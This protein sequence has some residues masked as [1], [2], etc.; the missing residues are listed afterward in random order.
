MLNLLLLFYIRL[1]ALVQTEHLSMHESFRLEIGASCH[2]SFRVGAVSESQL[3][4]RWTHWLQKKA[5]ISFHHYCSGKETEL[6]LHSFDTQII[7]IIKNKIFKT[8]NV[9]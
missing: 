7:T 8:K 5:E 6:I 1:Q 2:L 4:Y 3:Y 9:G